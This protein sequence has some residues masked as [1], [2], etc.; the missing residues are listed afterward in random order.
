MLSRTKIIIM[1]ITIMILCFVGMGLSAGLGAY[2]SCHDG[3]GH[4]AWFRTEGKGPSYAC[5]GYSQCELQSDQVKNPYMTTNY[6]MNAQ[7][8]NW[9]LG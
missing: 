4:I 9:T 5:V 2:I 3:G 1:T 8:M 6:S 7:L